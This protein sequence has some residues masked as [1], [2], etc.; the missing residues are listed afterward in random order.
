MQIRA[1]M[2]S[3]EDVLI[4]AEDKGDTVPAFDAA[5]KSFVAYTTHFDLGAFGEFYVQTD[6]SFVAAQGNP[7]QVRI[8]EDYAALDANGVDVSTLEYLD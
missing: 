5:G 6:K 8:M 7:A 1:K 2:K 3:G 4:R